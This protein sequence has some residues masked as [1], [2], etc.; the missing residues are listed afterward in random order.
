MPS[1]T[2]AV[3]TNPPRPERAA[4]RPWATLA[5]LA[6]I[7][8]I[9]TA[10]ELFVGTGGIGWPERGIILDT[11]LLRLALALIVGVALSVSGVSLQALL[12]NPLAEPF[13]L[14]LSSGAAVGVVVQ[15]IFSM[16]FHADLGAG[17]IGAAIGAS[18]AMAVVFLAGRKRGHVDPLG[19]LLVGVVLSTINGAILM[20]LLY[21]AGKG[22]IR[23]DLS[24]WMMGNLN[25]GIQSGTIIVV[26]VAVVAG[27]TILLASARAMD[28]ATFSDAEARSM[29]VNLKRLRVALFLAAGVLTAGA[30]VLGGPIAFVGLICPHIARLLVGASHRSLLIASAMLGASLIIFSDVAAALLDLWQNIGRVPIGIFTAMLGGPMFLWMLRPSL[31]R[32]E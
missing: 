3:T 30:V 29:G 9:A 22:Q 14:G 31:G 17:H 16:T 24:R 28:V 8:V 2:P 13:I 4:W 26:A 21:L 12:R 1:P 11:R 18:V 32:G 20:L 19:L 7:L 25:E 15:M 10:A 6:L 23:D 27:F 5:I